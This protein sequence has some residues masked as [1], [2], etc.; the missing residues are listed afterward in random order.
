M[1]GAFDRDAIEFQDHIAHFDAGSL[2]CPTGEHVGDNGSLRFFQPNGFRRHGIHR[3]N[4][5][6]NVAAIDLAVF[7]EVFDH[8]PDDV[9]RNSKTVALVEA[10]GGSN[11]RIDAD[12][13]SLQRKEPTAAVAGVDC[14]I[15]LDEVL[16]RIG[17]SPDD[18]KPPTPDCADD[19]RRHRRAQ[20]QRIPNSN[21]PLADLDILHVAEIGRLQPLGLDFQERQVCERIATD[22]FRPV[23]FPIVRENSDVP[24][25]C[26]GNHVIVRDNVPVLRDNDTGALRLPWR[27]SAL[28][29]LLLEETPEGTEKLENISGLLVLAH[30]ANSYNR[31]HNGIRNLDEDPVELSHT[32][33]ELDRRL[34]CPKPRRGRRT[35]LR[36]HCANR[37]PGADV[38]DQHNPEHHPDSNQSDRGK[39]RSPVHCVHARVFNTHAVSLDEASGDVVL[40]VKDSQKE[41]RQ[42][43][44]SE[45]CEDNP[46][47]LHPPFEGG[48]TLP[49][50]HKLFPRH[51]R[52]GGWLHWL[53]CRFLLCPLEQYRS[54]L[55]QLR[56]Q[57]LE[58]RFQVLQELA[59]ELLG[60]DRGAEFLKLSLELSDI[61][62]Q[63]EPDGF[64][65][66]L[67]LPELLLETPQ[68]ER[69]FLLR[70]PNQGFYLHNSLRDLTSELLGQLLQTRRVRLNAC[71]PCMELVEGCGPLQERRDEGIELPA[72][73]L[74]ESSCLLAEAVGFLLEAF[75]VL[76]E[77]LEQLLYVGECFGIRL[78]LLPDGF[79]E[80]Q[81]FRAQRLASR[82]GRVYSR[83]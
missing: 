73:M 2:R 41:C 8:S 28:R 10:R 44:S 49:Q 25:L 16:H 19:A 56:L 52:L 12:E 76:L 62:P 53:W 5:H 51:W 48:K 67:P 68:H 82:H 22:D 32:L 58:T 43:S 79:E 61:P 70:S 42:D 36:Q 11:R 54:Q 77:V 13:R 15:G 71:Q 72:E 3:L 37:T 55:C 31:R 59:S 39:E 18:P 17:I 69:N 40:A 4:L 83:K 33:A 47:R 60:I 46:E 63:K 27:G 80:S 30:N 78:R 45:E 9:N 38:G 66:L 57:C 21:D 14:R 6:S 50:Q 64:H 75:P 23:L 20:A 7:H 65:P 81:N 74:Q 29:F 26:A 35:R 24:I 1:V 34:R